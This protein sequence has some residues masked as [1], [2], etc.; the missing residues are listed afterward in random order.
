MLTMLD[1]DQL[2]ALLRDLES[3]R[4]ERKEALSDKDRV[5]EAICAF[6]N[7]LANNRSEGVAFIGADDKGNPVGLPITDQLLLD[8]S[9]LRS[10][11]NIHP[12]PSMTVQKR[13]VVG[14]DLA[15]VE[16]L[17][18]D[19]TPIRFKG[20]TCIRVGPRRGIATAEEERRLTEKRRAGDLPFDLRPLPRHRLMTSISMCFGGRIYLQRSPG[21]FLRRT[22]GP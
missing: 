4:V 16:V 2:L 1:D 8:L 7:D 21:T 22:S 5:C 19:M 13:T 18:S 6:A 15:V 3:D 14:I 20:R 11:G 12:F 17:P 9:D 10:N